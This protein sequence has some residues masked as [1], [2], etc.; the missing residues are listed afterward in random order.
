MGLTPNQA[1]SLA[2]QRMSIEQ[3]R[4]LVA[5]NVLAGATYSEIATA[6]K[7][8]K[9]TVASDYKAIIKEW[10]EHY[11]DKADQFL[12]LQLRRLDMLLNSLW[13]DAQQGNMQK[14][15]R[16]LAIMDRQNTLLGLNKGATFNTTNV[17]EM[18]IQVVEIHYDTGESPLML[19]LKG[20]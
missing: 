11:A 7:V 1:H 10:R 5:A 18:P 16:A 14:L 4:K 17:T 6:L 9:G 8:S 13:T 2:G 3:R 12:A 19:E 20:E 15:D